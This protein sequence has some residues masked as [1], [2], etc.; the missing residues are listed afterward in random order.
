MEAGRAARKPTRL[1][2]VVSA[3]AL[4][5]AFSEDEVE[6]GI[7][8]LAKR[9]GVAKSTAH[10][11]AATLVAEGL[12]EQDRDSGKYRLGI[13]L[14][15][16]GA[17]VRQRMDVSS[18]AKSFLYDLRE[19][20]NE[21]VH[22][23]I[24]D[25]VEIMYVYNLESTQ[26]IRMRS[27]I[28]VRK[29]AYCTAEGQ[30]ILAFQPPDVIDGVIAAGLAPRTPHTVTDAGRLRDAFSE[31][32]KRGG[33]I[34]DEESEV[35]MRA[36]AA[37]IRNDTGAVIAAVGVAGPVTRLSKRTIAAFAPHVIATAAA[38]SRRLGYR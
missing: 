13:A 35:G 14:F 21:S 24:L 2:S 3:V 6:F 20:T 27:D 4:L 1:S 33:A 31:I 37:P 11:L 23:A 16:L 26:A 8:A 25:G 36:I 15:R 38:I 9:L 22:L 12:L 29:P 17:L 32:R 18:E 10:R 19:T 7:S 30:A 28:G 34:E 5:K